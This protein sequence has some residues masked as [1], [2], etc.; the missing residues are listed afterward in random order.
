MLT[1][2]KREYDHH[3]EK[4]NNDLEFIVGVLNVRDFNFFSSLD[5]NLKTT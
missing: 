5:K 2:K 3:L 4:E 1:R